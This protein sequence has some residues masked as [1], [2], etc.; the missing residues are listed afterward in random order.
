M[1]NFIGL[2]YAVVKNAGIDTSKM[3]PNEVVD[4]YNE[5]QKKTGQKDATPKEQK[6]MQ[7]LGIDEK[8]NEHKKEE[9]LKG[10]KEKTSKIKHEKAI[11]ELSSDKYPDGTYDI[12]NKEPI[13]YEGGYQVTFCQIGDNYTEE[14]HR[15]LC[16]E[17]LKYSTDDKISAG[18]FGGTP[19]IS[20]NVKDREIAERLAKK[21]NQISI[22]DWKT[23]NEI[24]TGGTGKRRD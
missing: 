5:L 21:Y 13:E 14:E 11:K 3:S 22:W 4:K 7:E 23:G 18:K 6:R 12:E 2:A 1:S 24:G 8:S 15:A 10:R 19:E 16:E 9:T 20:F 17:F